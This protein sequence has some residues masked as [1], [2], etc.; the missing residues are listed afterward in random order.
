[1]RIIIHIAAPGSLIGVWRDD[2]LVI[3]P[4][5]D[6]QFYQAKKEA[7][8]EAARLLEEWPEPQIIAATRKRRVVDNFQKGSDG[9]SIVRIP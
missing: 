4:P 5:G 8:A 9:G 3:H 7:L 6:S 1:M 2:E